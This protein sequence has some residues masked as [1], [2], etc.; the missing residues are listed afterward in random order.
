MSKAGEEEQ[1]ALT[2]SMLLTLLKQNGC[3]AREAATYVGVSPTTMSH[4]HG[5]ASAQGKSVGVPSDEHLQK[6]VG[7]LMARLQH[8]QKAIIHFI[9]DKHLHLREQALIVKFAIPMLQQTLGELQ[10][11]QSRF[12]RL[13]SLLVRVRKQLGPD[14][15][16]IFGP[17]HLSF[18]SAWLT[19]EEPSVEEPPIEAININEALSALDISEDE[20]ERLR[21][22][23]AALAQR[24]Q[25]QI[26]AM[27]LRRAKRKKP[28]E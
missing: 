23:Y 12:D 16:Q 1:R 7:L 19:K 26:R 3:S 21:A 8:N 22:D 6:L 11:A 14:H 18:G 25:E 4:W 2:A 5:V 9:S 15:E 27:V 24:L 20:A 17:V 28:E 13:R 10:Q